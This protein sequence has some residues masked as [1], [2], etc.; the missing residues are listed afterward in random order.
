MIRRDYKKSPGTQQSPASPSLTNVPKKLE[1]TPNNL[2]TRSMMK[3]K[4]VQEL[5]VQN[6]GA[7]CQLLEK[8]SEQSSPICER[9]DYVKKKNVQICSPNLLAKPKVEEEEEVS[10]VYEKRILHKSSMV[11]QDNMKIK[12]DSASVKSPTVEEQSEIKIKEEVVDQTEKVDENQ[13][14]SSKPEEVAGP[15]QESSQNVNNINN[16]INIILTLGKDLIKRKTKNAKKSQKDKTEP[17]EPTIDLIPKSLKSS[18]TQTEECHVEKEVEF[19]K[20]PCK[21]SEMKNPLLL[22][23]GDIEKLYFEGNVLIVIQ[24]KTVSYFEYETLKQLISG[25]ISFSLLDRSVRKIYDE[26]A[27]KKNYHRLCFNHS[28]YP[29]Y[30]EMRGKQRELEDFENMCPQA[31]IYCQIYYIDCKKIKNSAVHL[32]TVKRFVDFSLISL[33]FLISSSLISFDSHKFISH[34]CHIV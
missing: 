24:E 3:R 25:N 2:S 32:D 13:S 28:E 21:V 7:K 18:E 23:D 33:N 15:E 8:S 30:I 20:I 14:S 17:A 11:I 19:N 10:V 9:V 31:F 27:D 6:F 4:V 22:E 1:K 34:F 12:L 26:E 16:N 29:I 5:Q